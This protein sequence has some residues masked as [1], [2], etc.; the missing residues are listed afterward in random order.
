MIKRILVPIDGSPS[1]D[2]ALQVASSIA[3]ITGADLLGLF[4]EDEARFVKAPPMV[5]A[6]AENLTGE[7]ISPLPMEPDELISEMEKADSEADRVERFFH[8]RCGESDVNGRFIRKVGDPAEVIVDVSRAV[9]FVV[10]GNSGEHEGVKFKAKGVTAEGLLRRTTRPVLVVPH[11][12]EGESRIVIAYDGSLAADRALRAAAELAEVTD[13]SEAH[14]ITVTDNKEEAH[15]IQAP[16]VDYLH[17]YDLE[18]IPVVLPGKAADV[19]AQYAKDI[20]ATILALGA[21]GSNRLKESIFGSTTSAMLK[22]ADCAV[23]LVA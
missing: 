2:S 10:L 1:A 19:I 7:A 17:A 3:G 20:D 22:N 11:D 15:L 18:V 13:M 14:L 9:D 21:F 4:V 12:A 6:V 16:A 5:L 23:L 8:E